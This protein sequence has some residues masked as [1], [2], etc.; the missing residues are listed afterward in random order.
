MPTIHIETQNNDISNIVIMPGDPKRAEYIAKK[1]LTEVKI[2]NTIRKMTAYTGLYKN[3]KITIFPS[4]MGNPS[5]G[6]YSYELFKNYNVDVIIRVGSMGSYLD[7]LKTNDILLVNNSISYS[8]YAK[9]LDNYDKIYVPSSNE[10]NNIIAKTAI[11]NQIPLKKGN[12]FC[13]DVFYAQTNDFQNKTYVAWLL[14]QPF[15]HTKG[16]LA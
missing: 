9:I 6:I 11:E 2:V 3:K 5:I 16:N 7:N 14:D 13:S 8:T 12:I 15:V 10:V 4:G 1:Y